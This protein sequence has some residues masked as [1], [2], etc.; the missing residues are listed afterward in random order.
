MLLEKCVTKDMNGKEVTTEIKAEVETGKLVINKPFVM[1]L[2]KIFETDYDESGHE[3]E[4]CKNETRLITS[5]VKNIKKTT[6]G[7]V[8]T[9]SSTSYYLND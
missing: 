4:V 3:I 6:K 2:N 7:M 9:T 5:P 1:T 8:V